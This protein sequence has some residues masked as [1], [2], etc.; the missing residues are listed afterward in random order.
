MDYK[1]LLQ[2]KE[3]A[4]QIRKEL[5]AEVLSGFD[6]I[7]DNQKHKA[8]QQFWDSGLKVAPRANPG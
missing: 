7:F 3:N 2:L 4:L 1:L 8:L 6:Y 5:P